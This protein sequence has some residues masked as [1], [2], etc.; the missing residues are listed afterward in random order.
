MNREK[1]ISEFIS[2]FQSRNIDRF[3]SHM[4]NDFTWV[5]GDGAVVA[6]SLKTFGLLIEGLWAAEPDLKNTVGQS[7]EIGDFLAHTESFWDYTDGHTEDYL[8][9]YEFEG[10][11]IVKMIGYLVKH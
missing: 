7:V 5:D 1:V 6:D 4:T 3:L 11:K 2:A 8:W 10:I 9:V